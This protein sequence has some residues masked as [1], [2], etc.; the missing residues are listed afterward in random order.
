MVLPNLYE[1]VILYVWWAAVYKVY[2]VGVYLQTIWS[3]FDPIPTAHLLHVLLFTQLH[4]A[5][6]CCITGVE[7]LLEQVKDLRFLQTCLQTWTKERKMRY[8]V[9][10]KNK[11]SGKRLFTSLLSNYDRKPLKKKLRFLSTTIHNKCFGPERCHDVTP[12]DVF[13][14][15]LLQMFIQGAK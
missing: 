2:E 15:E 3:L 8:T 7:D 4:K 14:A 12:C 1:F 6:A 13:F 9:K 5:F 10:K 11:S